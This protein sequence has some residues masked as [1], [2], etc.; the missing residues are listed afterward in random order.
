MT[1]G[2]SLDDW[3]LLARTALAATLALA[4]VAK[5]PWSPSAKGLSRTDSGPTVSSSRK[6]GRWG[7][8]TG[9]KGSPRPWCWA[10][11]PGWRAS[12]CPGPAR[13]VPS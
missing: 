13:S 10:P 4:A 11:A 5:P 9:A 1:D 3:L 7:S 12:Q 8:D 2:S 6:G